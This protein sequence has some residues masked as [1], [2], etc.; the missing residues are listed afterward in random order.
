LSTIF[1]H[2][3]KVVSQALLI[4][5][6]KH[7]TVDLLSHRRLFGNI[8]LAIGILDELFCFGFPIRFFSKKKDVFNEEA[9]DIVKDGEEDSE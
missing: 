9:K 4:T 5:K 6:V 3:I 1:L 2:F 7:V 8:C